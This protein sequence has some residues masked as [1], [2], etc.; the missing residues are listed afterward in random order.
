MNIIY[1]SE[2]Q[3]KYKKLYFMIYWAMKSVEYY[4]SEKIKI[5]SDNEKF[6]QSH[7]F[8]TEKNKKLAQSDHF[9]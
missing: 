1:I 7:W 6:S 8:S 9:G 5:N 4:N 3:K 2:L